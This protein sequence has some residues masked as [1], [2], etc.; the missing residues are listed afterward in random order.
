MASPQPSSGS[1]ADRITKDTD[2]KADTT[3]QAAESSQMDG[4][5]FQGQPSGLQ[6]PE[7]DVVVKLSDKLSDLQADPDNPLYSAKQ[8]EDL[9]L[10][11]FHDTFSMNSTL[12]KC[13]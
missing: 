6:E 10:Y 2:T 5:A 1:L 12:T 11:A 13:C 9:N 8:F 4:A 3:E 7:V